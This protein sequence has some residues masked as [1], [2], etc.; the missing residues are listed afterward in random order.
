M[1]M[2]NAVKD[3]EYIN[4]LVEIKR[5]YRSDAKFKELVEAADAAL[6]ENDYTT[7][8]RKK[9]ETLEKFLTDYFQLDKKENSDINYII[10]EANKDT[11]SYSY[12]INITRS[13]IAPKYAIGEDY[14]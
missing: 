8:W 4:K 1:P 7:A 5:Y 3:T 10:E 6:E 12:S 9:R 14:L 11:N 2:T 13:P